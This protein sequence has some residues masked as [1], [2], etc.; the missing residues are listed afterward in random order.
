LR[1]VVT[2][3]GAGLGPQMK[4]GIGLTNTRAR[5]Q[6]MFGA[7]HAFDIGDNPGGGAVVSLA[8]PLQEGQCA[9]VP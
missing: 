4:W 7:S 5:L 8:I 9:S 3:D 2:D 6:Q 1:L